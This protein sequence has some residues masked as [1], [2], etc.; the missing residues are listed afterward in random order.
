MNNMQQQNIQTELAVNN[1]K[2][3]QRA[4]ANIMEKNNGEI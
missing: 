3:L 4:N 2:E 1:E